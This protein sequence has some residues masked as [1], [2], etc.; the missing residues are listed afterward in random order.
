MIEAHGSNDSNAPRPRRIVSRRRLLGAGLAASPVILAGLWGGRAV[1]DGMLS[2]TTTAGATG[3]Q[4]PACV[5]TPQQTEG[6]Y[7]VDE[8][9]VRSD[10][11]SDPATGAIKDGVPLQMEF[12]VSQVGGEA[13]CTPLAGAA[14][15]V[16]QCDALGVYSDV[17]DASFGNTVGQKFLRGAQYTDSTG[18]A[19]FLTIYPGWYSGRTVHIHFKVRTDPNA[20]I[21]Y[22]FTSQLYFD[23]ELTDRVHAQA[24]YAA[25]GQ[26]NTRNSNDGIFRDGGEQLLLDIV[27][28]GD[29]YAATIDI[30]IDLSAAP[31]PTQRGP[32][33]PGGPPPPGGR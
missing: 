26:R 19:Q 22:E 9:I 12:R 31:P 18:V 11:R 30:G 16:W 10:I 15:D 3:V 24:P 33:G 6:P 1:L 23:D 8:M 32:G 28:S 13:A 2:M 14:V 5:V 27:E 7:F 29:G 20:G 21:G 4:L 17:Q 25:K